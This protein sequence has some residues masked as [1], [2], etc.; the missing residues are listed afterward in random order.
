MGAKLYALNVAGA[1]LSAPHHPT[2]AQAVILFTTRTRSTCQL[3]H[4]LLWHAT[5]HTSALGSSGCS[6][7][8]KSSKTRAAIHM[9]L[10]NPPHI[11]PYCILYKTAHSTHCC[12]SCSRHMHHT[13]AQQRHDRHLHRRTCAVPVSCQ[14]KCIAAAPTLTTC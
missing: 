8:S 2:K 5:V 11:H 10:C 12:Q 14:C 13:A 1:L 4:I 6:S 7:S 9:Q 3:C